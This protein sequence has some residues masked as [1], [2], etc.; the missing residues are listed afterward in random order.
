MASTSIRAIRLHC[1]SLRPFRTRSRRSTSAAMRQ[2]ILSKPRL[3]FELG[4]IAQRQQRIVQALGVFG[5]QRP[6]PVAKL[7]GGR[8]SGGKPPQTRGR[9]RRRSA[10]LGTSGC[11][12]RVGAWESGARGEGRG[13]A[14]LCTIIANACDGRQSMRRAKF[15]CGRAGFV[16]GRPRLVIE[17]W[18]RCSA[19]PRRESFPSGWKA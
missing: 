13:A 3:R 4:A 2:R 19:D 8:I 9:C 11:R 14:G 6:Q 5:A 16:E 1:A 18:G 15:R 12:E 7:L 10:A 17:R